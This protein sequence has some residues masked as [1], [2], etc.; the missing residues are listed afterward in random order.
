V[1]ENHYLVAGSRLFN[2][3]DFYAGHDEWEEVWR[4][5]TGRRR[6][7]LHGLIQVAVGYEHQRRGNPRGMASLLTQGAT[8]LRSH[9]RRPGV[10]ELRE[11]ALRDADIARTDDARWRR[12]APPKIMLTLERFDASAPAAAIHISV[13][14]AGRR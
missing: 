14:R 6:H 3:R 9:V 1:E 5:A 8:K 7:L 4:R 2:K 10:R 11:R 13:P 12:L